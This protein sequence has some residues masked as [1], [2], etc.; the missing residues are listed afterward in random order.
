MLAWLNDLSSQVL[1]V[2]GSQVLPMLF[3]SFSVRHFREIEA[4]LEDHVK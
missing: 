4:E 1:N 2:I 3:P